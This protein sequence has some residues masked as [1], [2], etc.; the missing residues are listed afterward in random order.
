MFVWFIDVLLNLKSKIKIV[1]KIKSE[2]YFN[3]V[4]K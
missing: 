2:M 1:D 4:G 3:E